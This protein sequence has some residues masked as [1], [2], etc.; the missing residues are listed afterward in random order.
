MDRWRRRIDEIDKQIVRLLGERT[1]LA[2]Q[3]GRE[4]RARGQPLRSPERELEVLA[5]VVQAGN[6]GPLSTHALLRIYHTILEETG[7]LQQEELTLRPPS[8]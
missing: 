7:R 3:I 6:Y 4:K 2:L 1:R 8:P 5:R